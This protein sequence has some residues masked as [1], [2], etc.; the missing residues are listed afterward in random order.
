VTRALLTLEEAA[1]LFVAC[2]SDAGSAPIGPEDDA[3]VRRIVSLLA[4]NRAAIRLAAAR[5]REMS[6]REIAASLEQ[7]DA[8]DVPEPDV[9]ARLARGEASRLLGRL[10]EAS[11]DLEAVLRDAEGDPHAEAEANRLLGA[12]YRAQGRPQEAL[13][14]KEKALALFAQIGDPARRAL[15]HGEV[16]TA[17]AALGRL[18]EARV[19]HE[20][21]LAMHRELGSRRHE[22][23]ELSYLGVTLHRLGLVEEAERAH[24]EALAI[25]RA[26]KSRR[27]EGADLLHL[28]YIAHERNALD[29]GRGRFDAALAILREV[30]DRALLG[31]ALGYKGALE[32]DAGRP[33]AAGPLLHQALAVHAEVRSPR[34]EATTWLHFAKHHAALGEDVAARR[35]LETSLAIGAEGLDPEARA[36]ALALLGRFDEA[37]AVGA[38]SPA[39]AAAVDVLAAAAE[40]RDPAAALDRARPFRSISSR[41]RRACAALHGPATLD[42]APD[43]R[44]FVGPDGTK[45]DLSRRRPLRLA[46]ALLVLRREEAPGA[47]VSWHAVLA[48][49]WPGERPKADAGFARVRNA[50]ATLRK[51]GLRDVLLTRDDGYLLDPSVAV[52]RREI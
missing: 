36:W 31:V 45:V 2:A 47:G 39:T 3:A 20:Q 18:R 21:A 19:Y 14:H 1:R 49:A 12:V 11:A 23:V 15:A 52:R 37:R 29:E 46:L 40:A 6:P 44:A 10:G 8:S 42:V 25:H 7:L 5:A 30:N 17:L 13:A 26:E 24:E 38:E 35:A 48:A 9:R 51:L 50:L 4:C 32:V 34:H 27:S 43:G 33:E 22:G 41:V 28:G 16:G